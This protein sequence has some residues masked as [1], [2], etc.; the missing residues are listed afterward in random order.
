MSR[1]TRQP[2]TQQ[3]RGKSALV[4][5]SYE[6]PASPIFYEGS[7]RPDP[8]TPAPGHGATLGVAADIAPPP[9]GRLRR[10]WPGLERSWQGAFTSSCLVMRPPQA[11]GSGLQRQ[12]LVVW[13]W[14][15]ADSPSSSGEVP[16]LAT[17]HEAIMAE[18]RGGLRVGGAKS[19][20]CPTPLSRCTS[21]PR[22][23]GLPGGH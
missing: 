12:V 1:S 20:L 14:R 18:S 4:T 9:E 16:T 10:S 23:P 3:G 7:P 13:Q 11:S 15:E 22:P 2:S 21:S 5:A 17:G 8:R 6:R 19:P